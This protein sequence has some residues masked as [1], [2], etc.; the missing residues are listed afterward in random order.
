[1]KIG[2]V[3]NSFE[4]IKS[5]SAETVSETAVAYAAKEVLSA[6]SSIGYDA[7]LIPIRRS[8]SGFLKR[9]K[10]SK[11]DAL[12]NLCEGFK[13]IPQ[14]ESC[15]ASIFEMEGIPFTGS[16]S[17]TLSICQDKFRTKSI[18]SAFDL[19]TPPS[20]LMDNSNQK[21]DMP[22]PLIVKP[23]KEDASIGIY[24]DSVVKNEVSLKAAVQKVIDKYKESVL[25]ESYIDGREFNVG[26]LEDMALPVSEIDF[27]S[28]PENVPN[29]CGYEAKWFEDN[30]L[31]SA[32]K[33]IC[34]APIDKNLSD[35]LQKIAK[36]AFKALGCRD[37][38]RIDFRMDE[39]GNIYILEVNPNP[40]ISLN[41]GFARMLRAADI[42]YEKF[43]DE[44]I[45]TALKRRENL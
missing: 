20:A 45:K 18:L 9:L 22:F 11:I 26:I 1:M 21:I 43:W 34:P 30:I 10:E 2:I 31:Y 40:D 14:L 7:I 44:V 23:N 24:S 28:M 27:S 35:I 8:L 3:Y 12:I 15:V 38:G 17:N 5:R 4:L 33:P 41:A 36:K 39:K 16:S 29:I 25:V 37:Y 13:G 42:P 32:T 19:P 6:V